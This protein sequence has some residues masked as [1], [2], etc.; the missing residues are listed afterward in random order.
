MLLL[1]MK[2]IREITRG[3]KTRRG[4]EKSPINTG[5][6]QYNCSPPVD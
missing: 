5:D 1:L 2:M 6:A 4:K 3:K